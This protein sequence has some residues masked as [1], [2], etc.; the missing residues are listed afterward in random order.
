MIASLLVGV[1]IGVLTFRQS[2]LAAA[3]MG[4][5]FTLG[6]LGYG[7]TMI[8]KVRTQPLI[9]ILSLSQLALQGVAIW[10]LFRKPRTWL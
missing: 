5:F 3:P 4:A 2:A 7:S 8:T 1:V 10:F 9:G 6:L